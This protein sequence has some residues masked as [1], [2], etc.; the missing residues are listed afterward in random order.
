MKAK[1]IS[2]NIILY[3]LKMTIVGAI[4]IYINIY[5]Y[6]SLFFKKN[7]NWKFSVNRTVDESLKL[8]VVTGKNINIYQHKYRIK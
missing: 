4:N 1:S 6:I 2:Y 8:V 7:P 5:I 3:Q